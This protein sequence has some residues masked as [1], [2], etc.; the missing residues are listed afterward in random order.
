MCSKSGDRDMLL[1]VFTSV[2]LSCRDSDER[3]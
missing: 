2:D 1:H 3:I